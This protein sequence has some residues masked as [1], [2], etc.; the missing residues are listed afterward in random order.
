MQKCLHRRLVWLHV[1]DQSCSTRSLITQFQGALFTDFLCKWG[2]WSCTSLASQFKVSASLPLVLSWCVCWI[3][4]GLL[5]SGNW[6]KKKNKKQQ[7]RG[8]EPKEVLTEEVNISKEYQLI[9]EDTYTFCLW[10]FLY[11]ASNYLNKQIIQRTSR[12]I[13][14][15]I[16]PQLDEVCRKG[17]TFCNGFEVWFPD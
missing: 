10:G 5:V 2:P 16:W 4:V 17:E 15:Y 9:S 3:F 14:T 11:V 6:R 12:S 13:P 1:A 8:L 7:K